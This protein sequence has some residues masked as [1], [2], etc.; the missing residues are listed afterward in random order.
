MDNLL[1]YFIFNLKRNKFKGSS[2]CSELFKEYK[3]KSSIEP[4]FLEKVG[5]YFEIGDDGE[6]C[7]FEEWNNQL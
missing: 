4:Y 2:I 6:S 7:C 3:E 1:T 5:F